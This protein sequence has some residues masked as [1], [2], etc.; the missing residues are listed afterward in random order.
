[1]FLSFAMTYIFVR[2]HRDMSPCLITG[3][4]VERM[5]GLWLCSLMVSIVTSARSFLD[6]GERND[7]SERYVSTIDGNNVLELSLL[8]PSCDI[9]RA[10][11]INNVHYRLLRWS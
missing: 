3:Q 10:S 11:V 7:G 6:D 8:L 2:T 4:G 9:Q 5:K 1:M